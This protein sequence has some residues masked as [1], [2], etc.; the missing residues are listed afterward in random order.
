M[1]RETSLVTGAAG[2]AGSTARRRVRAMV[3]KLDA[4]APTRC[5][6]SAP[7]SWSPTSS[8]SSPCAP[9]C[10]AAQSSS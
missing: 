4:G 8:T 1:S 2:S 10:E 5:V 6:T 9:P 3:R 7:K